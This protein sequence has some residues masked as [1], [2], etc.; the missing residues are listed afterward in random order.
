MEKTKE[1]VLNAVFDKAKNTLIFSNIFYDTEIKL[2][3]IGIEKYYKIMERL[4][5]ENVLSKLGRGIYYV[6]QKTP[7]GFS[8]PSQKQI[9][10]QIL[11]EKENKGI[12]IGYGL[13]N[14]LGI[15]TQVCKTPVLY[16]NFFNENLKTVG[17]VIV[18][19]VNIDIFTCDIKWL[20]GIMEVLENYDNIQEFNR[21]AF[22]IYFMKTANNYNDTALMCIQN[23]IGYKKKTIAFLK[24]RLD[25]LGI[26]NGLQ[27]FL[28]KMSIYNYPDTRGKYELV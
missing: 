1:I 28:C 19:R 17:G 10:D 27:K 5:K 23:A 25:K 22:W 6:A 14:K 8:V 20:I 16:S 12:E 9:I 4:V 13:Y 26:K 18:K 3:N 2:R 11:G 7:I 24:D 21:T 15:T